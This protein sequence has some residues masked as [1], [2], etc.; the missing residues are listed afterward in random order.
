MVLAEPYLLWS[1]EGD[2]KL[3]DKVPFQK[4]NEDI[5]IV[6]DL[7]PFRLRKIRILN[8]AQTCMTAFSYLYDNGGR[9]WRI[10]FR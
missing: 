4:I 8:A 3:P 9:R 7:E 6:D 1:I 10:L 2:G 5:P